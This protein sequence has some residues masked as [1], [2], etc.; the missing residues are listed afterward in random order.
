MKKIALSVLIFCLIFG[1]IGFAEYV[2]EDID[3]I[4]QKA[5]AEDS[6]YQ[7]V[8]GEI[9][10]R[11]ERGEEDYQKALHWLQLSAEKE[12][13]IGLFNLGYMCILSEYVPPDTLNCEDLFSRA[14]PGLQELA[15][16][17]DARAQTEL[18]SLYRYG[19]GGIEKDTEKSLM[20]NRK[21]VEQGFPRAMYI[22]GIIYYNGLGVEK[23]YEE[24]KVWFEKLAEAGDKKSQFQLAN[25]YFNG[26]GY[27]KDI[28]KALAMFKE[29]QTPNYVY[30][31]MK[32]ERDYIIPD[33][34]PPQYYLIIEEG[35]CGECCLWSIL[36]ARHIE[37]TQVEINK[38]GGD[39]GRG[40]HVNELFD[41][42]SEYDIN[43]VNLSRSLGTS[44]SILTSKRYYSFLDNV[45]LKVE[46]G[47][48]VLIGIKVYPTQSPD[49]ACDHFVLVIG[50]NE[51][52]DEL[53]YN[54]N[55]RRKRIPAEHL[56]SQTEMGYSFINKYN[57]VFAIEFT[58]F[59]K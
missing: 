21:A 45:I 22:E 7:G 9:Y 4:K 10:Y 28:D 39:P 5:E 16:K 2:E 38:A 48:P 41:V 54:D 18:S 8:L 30:E 56:V 33:V 12:H 1:T 3:I 53:I 14:F 59:Q 6:Y 23:D 40:L 46:Q 29:I 34:L 25:M 49:W 57:W 50:Y 17:G 19:W 11:G 24:A 31:T 47:H 36:Q 52:T 26:H 44:D 13:P 15:E 32:Q 37:A 58:D 43:F 35:S 42:L 27:E 51:D 55:V 20:W